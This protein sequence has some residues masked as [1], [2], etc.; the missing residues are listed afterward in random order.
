MVKYGKEF[1]KKQIGD[2]KNKYFNYKEYKQL[3]KK[4]VNDNLNSNDLNQTQNQINTFT[5]KLNID[6]KKIFIYFVKDERILYKK[7]NSHLYRRENYKD[8]Q[9]QEFVA[10]LY[11]LYGISN[12]SLNLSS[13][14]YYNIKAIFK[15]LKKF[16]KKII[17]DPNKDFKNDFIF[18]NIKEENSDLLYLYKFKIIDEV[19]I[20]IEDLIKTLKKRFRFHMSLLGK[21]NTSSK[22]EKLNQNDDLYFQKFKDFY[23]K[24]KINLKL[25]DKN[26]FGFKFLFLPWN[27][28]LKN[29][30]ELS[31][32]L[33]KIKNNSINSSDISEKYSFEIPEQSL[34]DKIFFSKENIINI[35]C[36]LIHTFLYMFTYSIVIPNNY[37][38]LI[39]EDG[40]S[41]KEK[42]A[43]LYYALIMVSVPIGTII[44]FTYETTCVKNSTK[45]PVI[46]SLS[47]QILGNI[48]YIIEVGIKNFHSVIILCLSRILIGLSAIRTTN[49][50]YLANFLPKN[51]INIFINFFDICT[52]L[53]LGSGFIINLI[54]FDKVNLNI[55]RFKIGNYICISLSIML[56]L[57]DIFFFKEAKNKDFLKKISDIESIL[58]ENSIK[59]EIENDSK[60]VN[61]INSQ[62]GDFNKKNNYDDTNLVTKNVFENINSAKKGLKS[63]IKSFIV[64][65]TIV[66]TSKFINEFFFIITPLYCINNENDIIVKNILLYPP[67][68]LGVTC[69]I[70]PIIELIFYKISKIANE[71]TILFIIYIALLI[72]NISKLVFVIFFEKN[73]DNLLKNPFFI[74]AISLSIILARFVEKASSLFFSNIM[75]NEFN[76][77]GINGNICI[78][79]IS[80]IGRVLGA[81]LPFLLAYMDF[82]NANIIFY[83]IMTCFSLIS[84]IIFTIYYN[85]LRIKAISRII[86]QQKP[87]MEVVTEI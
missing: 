48:L 44:S 11:E 47:L 53:G 80:H 77:F 4:M 71:K 57:I 9:S 16:N 39:N 13:Y 50:M 67:I 23:S 42:K 52:M 56:L 3:I 14:V 30:D 24:T 28:Y 22:Q 63:L 58:E 43:Y 21:V 69:Y 5:E 79:T 81:F 25:I 45:K 36:T 29:K 68:I 78:N 70:I 2:Y 37:Y 86:H 60:M 6:L 64:F 83:S 40:F 1:R 32:K 75:P 66:F 84:F 10:E 72:L 12:N 27:N 26:A 35:I 33:I 38:Y 55:E 34:I 19:N 7:I 41:E 54:F 46:L 18:S 85:D 73:V 51:K 31:S 65:S 61:E 49:K 87:K 17:K 76:I 82:H 8:Y 74:S 59:E 15:I 20:L 62:L